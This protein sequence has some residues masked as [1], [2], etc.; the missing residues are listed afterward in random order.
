MQV[1]SF[2]W[3]WQ[4]L[5]I[6]EDNFLEI[7]KDDETNKDDE[8]NTDDE[9]NKYDEMNSYIFVFLNKIFCKIPSPRHVF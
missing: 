8:M 2:F 4:M 1:G 9:L 5:E 3:Y 7:N 6:S